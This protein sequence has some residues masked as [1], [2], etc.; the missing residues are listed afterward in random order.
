MLLINKTSRLANVFLLLD[1][2]YGGGANLRVARPLWD[3]LAGVPVYEDV[4]ILSIT[5]SPQKVKLKN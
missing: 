1:N 2:R 4:N 5:G 3:A